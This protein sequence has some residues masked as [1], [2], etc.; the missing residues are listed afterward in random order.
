MV[1]YGGTL[2][3]MFCMSDIVRTICSSEKD[4]CACN[5]EGIFNY[6]GN[7]IGKIDLLLPS[8][9]KVVLE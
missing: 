3:Q 7:N 1:G 4:T 2:G 8:W 6:Y 5:L 9:K